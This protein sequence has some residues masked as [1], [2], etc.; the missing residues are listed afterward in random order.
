MRPRSISRGIREMALSISYSLD[1]AQ[2]I[3]EP[4]LEQTAIDVASLSNGGVAYSGDHKGHTTAEFLDAAGNQTGWVSWDNPI[5]INS[6]L[7]QLSNGNI[8]IAADQSTDIFFTVIDQHGLTVV[9]P[10]G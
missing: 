4:I 7:S 9:S 10:R 2:D 5:G 8:I 6:S 1:F 3:Y